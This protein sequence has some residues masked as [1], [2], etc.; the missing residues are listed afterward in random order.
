MYSDVLFHDGTFMVTYFYMVICITQVYN[1]PGVGFLRWGLGG[2]LG[3][4]N[5]WALV[6]IFSSKVVLLKTN[7]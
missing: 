4:K 7:I 6:I 1:F 2:I 5:V 3:L